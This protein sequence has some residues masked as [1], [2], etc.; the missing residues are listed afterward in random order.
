MQRYSRRVGLR[1]RKTRE[2]HAAS[3]KT[4]QRKRNQQTWEDTKEKGR[5][6][7]GDP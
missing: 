5:E 4:S 7:D 3:R 1:A 6:I 2:L